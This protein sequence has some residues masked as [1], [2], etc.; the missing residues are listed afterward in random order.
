MYPNNAPLQ[1][2]QQANLSNQLMQSLQTMQHQGDYNQQDATQNQTNAVM[3]SLI[4]SSKQNSMPLAPQPPQN[5]RG[6]QNNTQHQRVNSITENQLNQHKIN[7]ISY[8]GEG[9]AANTTQPM[10]PQ[11]SNHALFKRRRDHSKNNKNQNKSA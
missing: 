6:R 8:A 7:T 5:A 2:N 11:S 3:N 4:L 10:Q 1:S 9:S